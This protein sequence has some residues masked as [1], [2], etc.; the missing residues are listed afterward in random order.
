MS[1][2]TLFL[3]LMRM[4]TATGVYSHTVSDLDASRH[5][6]VCVHWDMATTSDCSRKFRSARVHGEHL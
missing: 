5:A 4:M 6:S 2:C 1:W 3:L